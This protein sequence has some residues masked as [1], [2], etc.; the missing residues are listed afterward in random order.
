MGAVGEGA[1]QGGDDEHG[2]GEGG[3]DATGLDGVEAL[4]LDKVEGDE[5]DHGGEGP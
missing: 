2:G 4:D 5:D 1:G 3:D